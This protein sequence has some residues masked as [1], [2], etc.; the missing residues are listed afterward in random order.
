MDY[1]IRVHKSKVQWWWT[2][3]SKNGQVIAHSEMYT[4]RASAM[5]TVKRLAEALDCMFEIVE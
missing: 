4:R 5:R 1:F 2:L 3:C